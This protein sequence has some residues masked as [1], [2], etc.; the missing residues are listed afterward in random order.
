MYV[1][2]RLRKFK[3]TRQN[4]RLN[5][6]LKGRLNVPGNREV[7]YFV[8]P[9]FATAHGRCKPATVPNTLAPL[10]RTGTPPHRTPP[11]PAARRG[12]GRAAQTTRKFPIYVLEMGQTRP[13]SLKKSGQRL[14][15]QSVGS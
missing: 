11:L 12:R 4:G 1:N 8:P 10:R 7:R 6:R 5:G 14:V 13:P 15:D 3:C 9:P 2:Q